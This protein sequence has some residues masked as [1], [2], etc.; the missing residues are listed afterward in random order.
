[1]TRTRLELGHRRRG[2]WCGRTGRN[3][4]KEAGGTG[5]GAEVRSQGPVLQATWEL[6][7]YSECDEEL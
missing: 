5:E 1:M 2:G 6:R 7:V 4:R 3:Q